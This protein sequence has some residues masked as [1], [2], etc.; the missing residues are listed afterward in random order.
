MLWIDIL[1]NSH[2]IYYRSKNKTT[3]NWKKKNPGKK[4]NEINI[5]AFYFVFRSV[6][7]SA[8]FTSG[9]AVQLTWY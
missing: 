7:C 5:L 2:K 4:L 9:K 6:N 3:W 8:L 1:L